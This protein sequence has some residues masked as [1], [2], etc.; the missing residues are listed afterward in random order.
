MPD[1]REMVAALEAGTDMTVQ[2]TLF[3]PRGKMWDQT[4]EYLKLP[5]RYL[6]EVASVCG[7]LLSYIRGLGATGRVGD[8]PTDWTGGP[9]DAELPSPEPA[10]APPGLEY[11]VEFRYACSLELPPP[12]H[13]LFNAEVGVPYLRF[14]QAVAAWRAGVGALNRLVESAEIEIA[15]GQRR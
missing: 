6:F 4:S 2:M 3:G 1:T 9:P 10:A 5:P 13:D 12:F 11:S 7:S 15:A 14:S 8:G